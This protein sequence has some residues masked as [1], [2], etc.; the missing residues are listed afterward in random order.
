MRI[1]VMVTTLQYQQK[2][3]PPLMMMGGGL[4]AMDLYEKLEKVGEGT[5]GKV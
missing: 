4:R 1:R 2:L 3:V 5:Y